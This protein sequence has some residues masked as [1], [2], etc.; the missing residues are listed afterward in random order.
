VV[1][2][3]KTMLSEEDV[4]TGIYN[5]GADPQDYITNRGLFCWKG[6]PAMN[7]SGTYDYKLNMYGSLPRG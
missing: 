3:K 7:L 4:G 1:E 5:N 2:V 6:F